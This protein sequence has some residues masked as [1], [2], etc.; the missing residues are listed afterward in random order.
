V[1]AV[2][3]SL[4]VLV[5]VC[6][7][8]R[9]L[10]R[11]VASLAAQ[12][13]PDAEFLFCDDASTDGSV[14][15]LRDVLDEQGLAPRARV[16]CHDQRRGVATTRQD[17]FAVATGRYFIYADADDAV[18]AGMY[19]G[20]LAAAESSDADLAWEGWIE[21]P[22][23]GTPEIRRTEQLAEPSAAALRRAILRGDLHG[24]LCNKLI[25]HDFAQAADASF[26][27][28]LT[29]CEDLAFLMDVL[30]VNPKVV[31]VDDCRYRYLRR[32]DSLSSGSSLPHLASL[33][34]VAAHLER[35]FADA[36][37]REAVQAFK[38]RFRYYAALDFTV[39]DH[40]FAAYF[41]E[42]RQLPS[43]VYPLGRR[44]AF[45]LSAHGLRP[46]VRWAWQLMHRGVS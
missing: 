12:N 13:V 35:L 17:L 41:P 43:D 23:D 24:S 45:W 38:A 14:E 8:A 27:E 42:I 5:A 1:T 19:A 33:Q 32:R 31:Y 2:Q 7:S 3:P 40:V 15:V 6:Q 34:Q 36:A 29:C 39:P 28:G 18:D 10:R 44:I 37:D 11:L 16:L 26:R 46:V 22:P 21:V 20:L 9:F 4:S 30:A 25:R